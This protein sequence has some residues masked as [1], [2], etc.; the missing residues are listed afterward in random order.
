MADGVTSTST[1]EEDVGKLI[2]RL[3]IGVLLLLHGIAKIRS[4]IGW[5]AGPLGNAGLPAFL[6]Y[7]VYVGEVVA[8]LLIIAGKFTRL[9]GV[10]VAINMCAAIMLV[11]RDNIAALNQGGGWAI[12]LEMLFLLGGIALFFLGSG[13]FALSRGA[14]RWD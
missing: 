8:P 3:A 11:Q 9:A 2:V 12:E 10:V 5:M 4:G 13:R 7:G 14:G 1:R 6:G